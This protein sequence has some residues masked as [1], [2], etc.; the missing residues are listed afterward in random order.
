MRPDPVSPVSKDWGLEDGGRRARIFVGKN[1]GGKQGMVLD[2]YR[3]HPA[4]S[5]L[6]ITVAPAGVRHGDREFFSAK[7]Q[8][9]GKRVTRK[10]LLTPVSADS[11]KRYLVGC[12]SSWF[13]HLACSP[14][15]LGKYS[16]HQIFL[17]VDSLCPKSPQASSNG[18]WATST[19]GSTRQAVGSG[20]RKPN[21]RL[22]R[23]ETGRWGRSRFHSKA[24][25][26]LTAG[27][28]APSSGAEV[29]G[30]SAANS[31]ATVQ[32]QRRRVLA[33]G[34]AERVVDALFIVPVPW[35]EMVSR[36]YLQRSPPTWEA[37]A[38]GRS[39]E[40]PGTRGV[41]RQVEGSISIPP[42]RMSTGRILP[43][44]CQCR[45]RP[46]PEPS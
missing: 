12:L 41:A 43:E 37:F 14:S 27:G 10:R 7:D 6:P 2:R 16:C 33:N 32:S 19:S 31:R 1:I 8:P 39:T 22:T 46:S 13:S 40:R 42:T 20:P 23:R 4:R 38:T 11:N 15:A 44:L 35:G 24:S 17:P 34:C 28:A 36:Q 25:K 45:Y 26:R 9:H 21:A 3:K 29:P 5:S 30:S 18:Q